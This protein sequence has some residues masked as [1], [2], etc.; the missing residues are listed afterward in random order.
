MTVERRF[1]ESD[2]VLVL[3]EL[4][5]RFIAATRLV[6]LQGHGPID[7]RW[8]YLS[9]LAA[10]VAPLAEQSLETSFAIL[11]PLPPQRSAAGLSPLAIG[12]EVLTSD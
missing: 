9:W 1:R 11:L 5:D 4:V 10:I 2:F 3:E 12:E 7:H 8:I 6:L